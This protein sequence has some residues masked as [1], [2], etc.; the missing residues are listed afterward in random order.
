MADVVNRYANLDLFI[1]R[2]FHDRLGESVRDP[3]RT[4]SPSPGKS[5]DGGR[6]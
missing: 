1:G 2:Q 6:R 4:A 5:M 3:T